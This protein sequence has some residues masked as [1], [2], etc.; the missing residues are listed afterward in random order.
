MEALD[1]Y[2]ETCQAGNAAAVQESRANVV[3]EMVKFRNQL[4]TRK[5]EADRSGPG[6]PEIRVI[7]TLMAIWNPLGYTVEEVRQVLGEPAA[8]RG[9][10]LVYRE[11]Y[12]RSSATYV[13]ESNGHYIMSIRLVPGA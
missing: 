13:L 3:K 7:P 2:A 11:V 9:S 10:E 4:A 5:T 12:R 1:R 6:G 8:S